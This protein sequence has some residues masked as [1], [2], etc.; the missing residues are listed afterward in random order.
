M[1]KSLVGAFALLA[2]YS[3][4]WVNPPAVPLSQAPHSAKQSNDGSEIATYYW[5]FFVSGHN[6]EKL[7]EAEAER[8]QKEHIGNLERLHAEGKLL[9]A[10]PLGDAG[11]L[12]GIV[13]LKVG[14]AAEVEECFKADPFVK[15]GRLE[16]ESYR[17][18][19][20]N[21]AIKEPGQPIKM[22]EY[23]L[24]VV[25]KGPAWSADRTSG[26]EQLQ[27]GHMRNIRKMA[28]AGILALAGPLE[29][30]GDLRGIF[31]FRTKDEEKIRSMVGED[32]AVQAA[33]LRVDLYP[34]Y[35]AAGVLGP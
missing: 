22:E 33:M 20:P 28:D 19:T 29:E 35:L 4:S 32:P 14:T 25:K 34:V 31:V 16:M 17:W 24:G 7:P 30:A 21:G 18:F 13:V 8:L 5:G 26:A 2:V 27:E 3:T 9:M 11:R 23:R 12:R 10:G 15:M 6:R 1:V